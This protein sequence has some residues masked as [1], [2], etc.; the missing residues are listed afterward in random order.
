[1]YILQCANGAYYIGS[2]HNLELRLSQHQKGEGGKFTRQFLPVQLVYS[3][4]FD[5]I[6]DASRR[7]KQVQGWSRKKK[8]ALIQGKFKL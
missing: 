1:M 8:I 2:T 7:E 6:E 3:E 5:C 4:V